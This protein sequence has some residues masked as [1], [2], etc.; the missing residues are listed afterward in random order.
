MR[1]PIKKTSIPIFYRIEENI[2][3]FQENIKR[4]KDNETKK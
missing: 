4:G 3:L 2:L 1:N